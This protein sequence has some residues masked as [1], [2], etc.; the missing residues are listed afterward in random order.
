MP[1]SFLLFG[2]CTALEPDELGLPPVLGLPPLAPPRPPPRPPLVGTAFRP[3]KL[4]RRA[5]FGGIGI[6]VASRYDLADY[7]DTMLAMRWIATRMRWRLVVAEKRD[8]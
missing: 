8:R 5:A 2:T 6:A 7:A 1:D 3:V 4:D